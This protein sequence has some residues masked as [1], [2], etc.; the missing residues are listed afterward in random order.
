M[1]IAETRRFGLKLSS[2]YTILC[3]DDVDVNDSRENDEDHWDSDDN[4]GDADDYYDDSVTILMMIL[5]FSL[6]YRNKLQW[7]FWAYHH[8]PKKMIT[9]TE[10]SKSFTWVTEKV[11]F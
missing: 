4:I 1:Q 9:V 8:S 5:M 11:M 6:V 7:L 2:F 3:D 10:H